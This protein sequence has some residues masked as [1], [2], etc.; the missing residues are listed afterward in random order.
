M[1][2]LGLVFQR[3]GREQMLFS[4]LEGFIRMCKSRC[5]RKFKEETQGR[6]VGGQRSSYPVGERNGGVGRQSFPHLRRLKLGMHLAE[7]AEIWE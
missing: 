6:G 7:A 4:N 3:V 1:F 2:V 5:E